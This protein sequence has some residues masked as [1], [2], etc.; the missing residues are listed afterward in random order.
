MPKHLSGNL[1]PVL[2]RL[3]EHEAAEVQVLEEHVEYEAHVE[4]VGLV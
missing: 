4:F 3:E 2:V 1:L